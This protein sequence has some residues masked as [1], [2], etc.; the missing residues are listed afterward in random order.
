M[1]YK[2]WD[3]REKKQLFQTR[4]NDDFI[5]DFA[6]D[7]QIGYLYATSGDNR[8]SITDFRN[9]NKVAISEDQED[10]LLCVETLKNGKKIVCGTQLGVLA[11]F[12]QGEWMDRSDNYPGHPETVDCIVKIDEDTIIT[13]SG[14]GILRV[15]NIHPNKILGVI[16]EHGGEL[17]I[18][19]LRKSGDNRF[20]GSISDT[21]LKFWN[22]EL[23]YEDEGDDNDDEEEEEEN[24]EKEERNNDDDINDEE[25]DEDEVGEDIQEENEEESEEDFSSNSEEDTKKYVKY[26]YSYSNHINNILLDQIRRENVH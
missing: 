18:K 26:Q 15:V 5:T 13:G 22:L 12:S 4:Q 20:L 8:L 16:G 7:P 21:S 24:N 14:D 9:R 1:K 2:I 11:I 10:E 19:S 23:F 17:P 6:I 3:L 25:E